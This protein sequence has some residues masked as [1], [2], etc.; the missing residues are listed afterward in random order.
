MGA[1]GS[2][3]VVIDTIMTCFW[4]FT[5]LTILFILLSKFVLKTPKMKLI[6]SIIVFFLGFASLVKAVHLDEYIVNRSKNTDIYEKYYVDTNKVNVTLPKKKRNLII[7]YLESMESS[8]F[9][10]EN[11]GAFDKSIIP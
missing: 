11:G 10:K 2:L 5:I 6:F 7:I 8:L 4:P 3:T 9:S 1:G